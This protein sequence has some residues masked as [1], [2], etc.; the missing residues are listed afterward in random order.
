MA[1]GFSVSI[2]ALRQGETDWN[3]YSSRAATAAARMNELTTSGF[4]PEVKTQIDTWA[5]DWQRTLQTISDNSETMRTHLKSA[6]DGYEAWDY[7]AAQALQDW[8][9]DE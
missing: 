3:D 5:E 9:T 4:T 8:L 6:A 7:T 1:D 2:G